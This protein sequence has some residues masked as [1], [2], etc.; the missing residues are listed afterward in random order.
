MVS[1]IAAL[2]AL[3]A[4]LSMTAPTDSF[5]QSKKNKRQEA[6]QDIGPQPIAI[7]PGTKARAIEV[8]KIV[9]RIPAGT[10]VGSYGVGPLCIAGDAIKIRSGTFNVDDA[11]YNDRLRSE[12]S[13]LNYTV[14][15]NPTALF[16]DRDAGRAELL[17]GGLIKS[18][19]AEFCGPAT[20]FTK[21][22]S[23]KGEVTVEWQV[24]DTLSRQVVLQKT[25]TGKAKV[26]SIKKDQIEQVFVESFVSAARN[27]LADAALSQLALGGNASGGNAGATTS[28]PDV[29]ATGP[30]PTTLISRLPLAKRSF[31]EQAV[32]VRGNVVT[33]FAGQGTGSGF[34]VSDRHLITNAH[35]VKGAKFLKLRL[36]TGR[37]ILGE[38]ITSDEKRDV[39]LIQSEPGGFVGLPIRSDEPSIG[40]QV[41]AVGSPLDE[42]NE[43]TVS[44]GIVSSYRTDEGLRWIQS[45]VNV[46]PGNSG[47]PLLD[48]KGNII[49][50][51]SWGKLDPRTGGGTGLNFFI[52]ITEAMAK[53]GLQFR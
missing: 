43:G 33:I 45:D 31:Q 53:L 42:G 5:A 40:S 25:T 21:E 23:G 47:G 41:F 1:K 28:A 37:E 9:A 44:A 49:G 20:V 22:G 11:T 12:L 30:I 8:D 17:I 14:V 26:D 6:P 7:P 19:S 29:T 48:D 35:V 10:S 34:F 13:A 4:A 24:Y 51:T 2:V 32:E 39:A 27:L 50:L 15:G 18:L 38:V 36:I 52:P 3:A 46:M 16:K